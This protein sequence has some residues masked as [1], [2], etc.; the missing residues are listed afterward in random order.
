V[1]APYDG[2]STTKGTPG[3]SG[4][5]KSGGDGVV[6]TGHRGVVGESQDY[7]GVYGHSI[8]NAGVVGVSQDFH[9][10]YGESH[11]VH[12]GALFGTNV[13]AGFGVI[14][15][16]LIGVSGEATT[17]GLKGV[18]V[19][20]VSP[21]GD[22]V[23]GR[24]H[25]GV[26]GESDEYQG[27]SGWSNGNAGVFGESNKLSGV[28]AISHDPQNAGL[29]ATNDKGGPAAFFQGNID[30][31]G[32][33]NMLGGD[34]AEDFDA[35]DGVAILPGSVVCINDSGRVGLSSRAYD[36]AVVGV[37]AGAT[38]FHPA[39]RLDREPTGHARL[40]VTLVG[41]VMCMVDASFAPVRAG[42]L[43]TSSE[44]PG[45][46]MKLLTNETAVGAI[47]GKALGPL[48]HGRGLIPVLAMLR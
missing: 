22:G 27:V 2:I 15:L 31:T 1:S 40:P 25:R 43:L 11:S 8:T 35:D 17:G 33:I 6:G 14:G 9:G 30:V 34:I 3:I 13:G 44:T 10:I 48:D 21:G 41:K 29:Y 37:V 38:G 12:N 4:A 45:H 16:G 46:A 26:R 24:G 36:T 42:D 18:G 28:Y 19:R 47:L 7:Q 20:G 5:N 23:F 39:L 32:A